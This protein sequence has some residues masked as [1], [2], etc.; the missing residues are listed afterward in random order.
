MPVTMTLL[1]C[2]DRVRLLTV[3]RGETSRP[4]LRFLW[5]EA[6]L[7]H[8]KVRVTSGSTCRKRT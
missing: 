3:A 2:S 1:T 5:S 7:S 8:G 4:G 6:S